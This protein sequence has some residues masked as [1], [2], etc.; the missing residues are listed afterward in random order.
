M[1]IGF[2]SKLVSFEIPEPIFP[3]P[4]GIPLEHFEPIP[5]DRDFKRVFKFLLG[6]SVATRDKASFKKVYLE[7]LQKSLESSGFT[8]KYQI[9]D[10]N[11]LVSQVGYKI[12]EIIPR[13]LNLLCNDI[14]Q[15]DVYC[16]YYTRPMTVYGETQR[17]IL[18]PIHFLHLIDASYPHICASKY[19]REHGI[20]SN[21]ILELDHFQLGKTPAWENLETSGCEINL[22][23]SGGMCNPLISISDL[24]VRLIEERLEQKVDEA[25]VRK[26][27]L[28]GCQ[29]LGKKVFF[30]PLGRD[31]E[32]K[33][34]A[35]PRLMLPANVDR[36]IKHPV[37][38]TIGKWP[39]LF[40]D[41]PTFV[42]MQKDAIKRDGCIKKY[43]PEDR[44]YWKIDQDTI[45]TL[46]KTEEEKMKELMAFGVKLPKFVP[47]SAFF[48]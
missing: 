33:R 35:T 48:T 34:Y 15:I 21:D 40:M 19:V 20:D 23:F 9:Y 12:T 44:T 5:K 29:I 30:H 43:R 2:D 1:I 4:D 28:D 46:D 37:T 38:F 22:Y 32:E 6:A 10:S 17:Q 8:S 42:G 25:S 27:L 41:T 47:P 14:E 7:S 39:E 45:V 11:L 36:Y 13:L 16:A 24:I 3:P 31:T 18:L 26:S